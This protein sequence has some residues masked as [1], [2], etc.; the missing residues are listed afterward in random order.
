MNFTPSQGLRKTLLHLWESLPRIEAT[1]WAS[2]ERW[3]SP[4]LCTAGRHRAADCRHNRS[5]VQ[6]RG[7]FL[8]IW[9]WYGDMMVICD[10]FWC[11]YNTIT[12]LHV[13][14]LH[15]FSILLYLF[16]LYVFSS[17]RIF[18]LGFKFS[19]GIVLISCRSIFHHCCKSKLSTYQGQNL[20]LLYSLIVPQNY[21]FKITCT[22]PEN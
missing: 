12:Q 21:L 4:K 20:V 17:K 6:G 5:W 11:R 22:P 15:S 19:C 14:F 18:Q 10:V 1:S 8:M 7:E 2:R 13:F 9:W 16:S 3:S